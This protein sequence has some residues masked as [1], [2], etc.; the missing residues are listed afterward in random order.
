MYGTEN[1]H[2]TYRNSVSRDNEQ[3]QRWTLQTVEKY[4]LVCC[5]ISVFLVASYLEYQASSTTTLTL[6]FYL[7][8][9]LAFITFATVKV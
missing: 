2:T 6:I 1:R 9:S 4:F 7:V 3:Y 5:R 8:S